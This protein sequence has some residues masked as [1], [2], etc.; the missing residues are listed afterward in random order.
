MLDVTHLGDTGIEATATQS[1]PVNT[2][3]KE[4]LFNRAKGAVEAGEQSLRD[5]A[6]ALSVAQ[7]LHG[8]SQAEMAR[9]IGKSEAWVSQLLRWRKSGYSGDSPFGP[10]TKAGRLKHAKDRAASGASKPR[11]PREADTEPHSDAGEVEA[12]L[13]RRETE[14][15]N[16]EVDSTT[17]RMSRRPRSPE[18]A[19]ALDE[20]KFAVDH[21]FGRMDHDGRREAVAYAQSKVEMA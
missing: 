16:Q 3:S 17:T 2:P 7:E 18:C 14:C 15:G 12:D 19:N 1:I 10:T 8:A 6:E 4:E 20:F 5:A 11:K 13:A 21:W 9:A